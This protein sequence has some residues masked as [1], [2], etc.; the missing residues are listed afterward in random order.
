MAYQPKGIDAIPNQQTLPAPELTG[1]A[2]ASGN[3][4]M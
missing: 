3:R 4:S 2:Q 1:R